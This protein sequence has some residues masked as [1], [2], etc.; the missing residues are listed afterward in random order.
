MRIF[1]SLFFVAFPIL[2]FSQVNSAK[3]IDYNSKYNSSDSIKKKKAPEATYDMYQIISLN[4]DTTY[5]DTTQSIRKAYSH[6]YLRKDNFGLLSFT[7][8]GQT[9]NTLQYGLNGFSP[10]P[11][12]GFTAKQ[13]NYSKAEDIRYA[14]VAT[15][16]TELYFKTTI[17]RGQSADSYFAINPSPRL[18]FSIAYKALRS[19]GRY[20]NQEARTGNFRFTTSYNTKNGRYVANAHY[21]AQKIQNEENGGISNVSDFESGDPAFDNRARLG[22]YFEDAMSVLKGKRFFVDQTF[23]INPK[24]GSNNLYVTEQFNYE[25]IYFNFTQ[26]T[27]PS[28]V[29]GVIVDRYGDSFLTSGIDDKTTYNKMY[30]KLGLVYE[31]MTLGAFTFF[32]DDLHSNYFYNNIL[33]L[34]AETVP[35]LLSQK[36]NTFGGQYNYRKDKWNGKFLYSKSVTD[37]NLFNLD[38]SAVYDINDE[39]QISFRY[40]SMNKLPNNNY[41]LYQSSYRKYNWSNDFVNEKINAISVNADTKWVSLSLLLNSVND[42][43]HFADVSTDAER[44]LG[45]QIVAPAQYG[46]AINYASLKVAKEFVV[47]KWALDNTLLFQKVDQSDFI[48]NVPEFVT[49]NTLYYSDFMFEKRLFLQIGTELN[50]F[51]SYYSNSYNPLIGEFFVQDRVKIG[52]YPLLDFFVNAKIQRTRIYL[53]AEHFNSLFSK[54]NYL[55]APDYPY[56]DFLIRFGLVWNFFN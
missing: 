55:S 45:T 36:I 40:Q 12:F 33:Y 6:N 54:N 11:E 24:K 17:Q 22:V 38:A 15:P 2:L 28:T 51:T 26:Q 56:R 35:N 49:R 37:Q 5:I 21:V 43:L 25:D 10:Y 34:D 1:F 46:K 20:I 44:A 7:N 27:V 42:Y 14:N 13:F 4:K 3:E 8:I 30:N 19:E 31:N 18:N 39:N 29:G 32:V 48:L 47:G 9:Y 23:R 16:V 50:Y 52:N 53:K 41:N